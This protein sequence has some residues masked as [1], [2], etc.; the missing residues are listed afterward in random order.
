MKKLALWVLSL[1]LI[2]GVHAEPKKL[3]LNK[4]YLTGIWQGQGWMLKDNKKIDF[5]AA[6]K[7]KFT[8]EKQILI[9]ESI[10]FILDTIRKDST[11]IYNPLVVMQSDSISKRIKAWIY[12]EG[13]PGIEVMVKDSSENFLTLTYK[14]NNL[15]YKYTEDC[16]MPN[17][18]TVKLYS[19]TDEKSWSQIMEIQ[20]SK[21][22]KFYGIPTVTKLDT[23]MAKINFVTGNWFGTGNYYVNGKKNTFTMVEQVEP[24]NLGG[25]YKIEGKSMSIDKDTASKSINSKI[26]SNYY[27]VLFYNNSAKKYYIQYYYSDGRNTISTLAVNVKDKTVQWDVLQGTTKLTQKVD[28]KVSG[29][30]NEQL[31]FANPKTNVNETIMDITLKHSSGMKP[32]ANNSTVKPMPVTVPAK[33]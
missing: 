14:S 2:V 17:F 20:Y 11:I 13:L 22:S 23:N 32:G 16:T 15:F 19:S 4:N 10:G 8:T 3:L 9:D 25:L 31:F 1:A 21:S 5:M 12:A 27:G 30:R 7:V 18:R 29:Q 28:Y 26:L 6:S 33:E 24:K